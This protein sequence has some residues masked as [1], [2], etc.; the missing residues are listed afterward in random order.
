MNKADCG[1]MGGLQTLMIHGSAQLKEWGK[2][3]GRP[4]IPTYND[5]IQ[6]GQSLE[7]DR[8]YKEEGSPLVLKDIIK[9]LLRK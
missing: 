8:N 4:R 3:G 1:R 6:Q 5:L 9:G 2:L 7:L